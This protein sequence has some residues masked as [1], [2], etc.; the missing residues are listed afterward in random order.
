MSFA[1]TNSPSTLAQ[2]LPSYEKDGS[3]IV[4]YGDSVIGAE[5]A[6]IPNAR[7]CWDI[8][9]EG[10]TQRQGRMLPTKGKNRTH[11]FEEPLQTEGPTVVGENSWPVLD[12]LLSVFEQDELQ[13]EVRGLGEKLVE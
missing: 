13:T 12:W 11:T 8:L 5:A 7:H 9:M 2:A 4:D 1:V 3:T 10:F 6:C